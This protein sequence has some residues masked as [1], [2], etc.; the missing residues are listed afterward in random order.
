MTAVW[1]NRDIL[2]RK[3]VAKQHLLRKYEAAFSPSAA[4]K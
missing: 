2:P 1:A 4:E 3:D